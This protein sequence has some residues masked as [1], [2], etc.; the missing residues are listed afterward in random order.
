[1]SL[2]SVKK[3]DQSIL[4]L[5]YVKCNGLIKKKKCKVQRF[6]LKALKQVIGIKY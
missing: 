1:M 4:H 3:S 5:S 6:G 2:D